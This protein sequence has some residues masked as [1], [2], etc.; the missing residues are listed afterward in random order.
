MKVLSK[1]EVV[2]K[3]SPF[4]TVLESRGKYCLVRCAGAPISSM[5][6]VMI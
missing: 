3:M 4:V 5:E 6:L 2:F 1:N